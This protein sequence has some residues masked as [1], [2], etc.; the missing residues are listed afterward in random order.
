MRRLAQ[1]WS[2]GSTSGIGKG[3]G[4]SVTRVVLGDP[5][6]SGAP[7][8]RLR[9]LALLALVTAFVLALVAT[10]A[11]ARPIVSDFFGHNGAGPGQLGAP[12]TTNAPAAWEL[13]RETGPSGVAVNDANGD[14][15]VGDRPNNRIDQFDSDYNFIRA[16]GVD[17]IS[18]GAAGTGDLTSGS[19]EVTS[20]V[21]TSRAFVAGQQISGAGIPAGTRVTKV[22]NGGGAESVLVLSQKATASAS[23][24]ALSV[25]AGSGNLAQNE[26]Q[27]ISVAAASGTYSLN[28]STTMPSATETTAEIAFDAS[29]ADV[30]SALEGLANIGAGNV[31]VS[32]AAGGPYTVEFKGGRFA[33]TNVAQMEGNTYPNLNG[34]PGPTV[35]VETV[36]D[37]AGT[38]EKCTTASD[39][40]QGNPSAAAGGLNAPSGVAVNQANQHVFVADVSNLRL[41]EY[42]ASG[43]FLRTSGADVV[44]SGPNNKSATQEIKV[45]ATGGTFVLRFGFPEGETTAT[46]TGSYLAGATEITSVTATEGAFTVGKQISGEGIAAGTTITAVEPG[47]L[48]ISDPT[49][50]EKSDAALTANL[51]FDASAATVEEALNALNP[52][53][54]AFGSVSVSG[55]PGNPGGSNPYEVTFGGALA[56]TGEQLE[57]Q[58]GGLQSGTGTTLS[59][60]GGPEG[61]TLTY[62]WLRDGAEIPGATSSTYTFA[63]A[64]AGHSIQCQTKASNAGGATVQASAPVVASPVPS[65]EPPAPPATIEAPTGMLSTGGVL[66][67]EPGFWSGEPGFGYQWLRNG[68]VIAGATESTY[69]LVAADNQTAIQCAVTGSNGSGAAVGYS[70]AQVAHAEPPNNGFAQGANVPQLTGTG[71]VGETLTCGPADWAGATASTYKWLR[72]GAFISGATASTYTLIGADAGKGI[73]CLETAVGSG[74]SGASVSLSISVAPVPSPVQPIA[75]TFFPNTISG[76]PNVG[77]SLT[78]EPNNFEG[79]FEEWEWHPNPPK[80]VLTFRWLRNGVEISG[81]TAEKYALAAADLDKEIQCV[82][83]GTNPSGST[84][85]VSGSG[86]ATVVRVAPPTATASIEPTSSVTVTTPGRGPEVCDPAV[87]VCQDGAS[88]GTGG[89][90]GTFS[91]IFDNGTPKTNAVAIAPGGPYAGDVFVTDV[92]S[93]RIQIFDPNNGQFVA[94][95]GSD[96]LRSGPETVG[97]NV[98]IAALGDVCKVGESP[99]G[100]GN[101]RENYGFASTTAEATGYLNPGQL[102]ID[103]NGAIYVPGLMNAYLQKYS[104]DLSSEQDFS[105]ICSISGG[106]TLTRGCSSVGVDPETN[107][108]YVV[109]GIPGTEDRC[110]P[111]CNQ[112]P[113]SVERMI[114]K[115]DSAG[116]Q[117]ETG[118]AQGLGIRTIGS[119]GFDGSTGQERSS[120][121]YFTTDTPESQIDVFGEAPAPDFQFDPI[122]PADIGSKTLAVRGTINPNGNSVHTFYRFETLRQGGFWTPFPVPPADAGNGTSPV[123]IETTITGL[124]P[125]TKYR[126][127][128]AVSKG[129]FVF[130]PEQ[131]FTTQPNGPEAE[132]GVA[133]WSGP[134]SS[135]PSLTFS[136]MVDSNNLAV[137]YYFEYGSDTSYGKRVP[138]YESASQGAGQEPF[139]ARQTVPGLDPNATYHYRLVARTD[140][141]IASGVDKEIGPAEAGG[142][143]PELVTPTDKGVGKIG[144]LL[145]PAGI[146]QRG[147]QAAASGNG[148]SYMF[149]YGDPQ[150][151]AGG[152]LLYTSKR[153]SGTWANEQ[154]NPVS[155]TTSLGSEEYGFTPATTGL[156][157][158]LSPELNCGF[159]QSYGKVTADTPDA[160][161]ERKVFNFYRRNEDGSFTLITPSPLN[162]G[163]SSYKVRGGNSDCTRVIFQTFYRLLPSVPATNA[164]LYEWEETAPGASTLR[165][166]DVLPDGSQ[167]PGGAGR[168]QGDNELMGG[169]VEVNAVSQP[170]ASLAYFVATSNEGD[171]SGHE[172]IFLRKNHAVTIDVSQSQTAVPND[173]DVEYEMATEDGS[174]V[175]FIAK[176]GLADNSPGTTGNSLYAYEVESGNLRDVVADSNPDDTDGP[177]VGGVLGA[178]ADGSHVYFGAKGQLVPGKGRTYAENTAGGILEGSFNV[179]VSHAGGL[180]FVGVTLVKDMNPGGFVGCIEGLGCIDPAGAIESRV[181]PS[182]Q[183]LLFKSSEA[184]TSY[185]NEGVPE[186]YRYSAADEEMA[187]VTC[188]QDGQ[189]PLGPGVLNTVFAQLKNQGDDSYLQRAM[190][191]DGGRIFFSSTEKLTP[192]AIGGQGGEDYGAFEWH[193]GELRLLAG[194]GKFIDVSADGNNA[195]VLTAEPLVPQDQ[196]QVK[197][198]YDYRV[199]GGF[200]Y[201]PVETCDPLSEGSC[202]GSPATPPTPGADPASGGFNG[203][204]NP[205]AANPKKCKKGKVLRKGKCVKKPHKAKHKKGKKKNG[206][207]AAKHGQGGSK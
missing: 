127:R 81:A 131:T 17:V 107:E 109:V 103:G 73:Q 134:P 183:H 5:K 115:L 146:K 174:Q 12:T 184:L 120:R 34:P 206:K 95:F 61:T 65:P 82:V 132:T 149:E 15:Y 150:A 166:V 83:V 163:A 175:F 20:V 10:P 68:A 60:D 18:A 105:S 171:D 204:G 190:S 156:V 55:G 113:A 191:E 147:W 62:Q 54:G 128:L 194:H 27:K 122:Q 202:Q 91:G 2:A 80:P 101:G 169:E 9:S 41:S 97:K 53:S 93:N 72:N 90:G 121:I 23:G 8:S 199:E 155:T 31:E 76:T 157:K 58:G 140:A 197:D 49:T 124:R 44:A 6:G 152:E 153:G 74:A 102:A 142:P 111:I 7:S 144:I 42:S 70:A 110:E 167:P 173:Q 164:H 88:F 148:M 36:Q 50:E 159:L 136:G 51:P 59:C 77:K 185:D 193:D 119:F 112:V 89:L 92:S 14:I 86:A 100:P 33:D 117:L 135:G 48:T 63:G 98:C 179:Y 43:D 143:F 114:V 35:L 22:A 178:A 200:P 45:A 181:S 25:A 133:R 188:R 32:G 26:Q 1:A 126:I 16:W 180:D 39:C 40:Q 57:I 138:L 30:Q 29:A 38:L 118:L 66:T 207:R 172:A 106:E 85:E 24:V 205:P 52:I 158:W 67:C 78:C 151:T 145:G 37:G 99:S 19:A 11:S 123:P 192:D 186:L 165:P 84:W 177:A 4:S 104:P 56:S 168:H 21:T 87:D 129:G 71:S 130:S 116:N 13:A 47:K 161:V 189:P 203:P 96:V 79:F 198:I 64:D 137:N 75:P 162:D 108:V 201:S 154:L 94:A 196:D 187:C 69:T 141:G 195:F 139:L 160:D 182:G 170:D 3:R 125:N 28:F 46:G 176:A